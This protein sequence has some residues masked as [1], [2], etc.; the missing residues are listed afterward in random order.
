VISPALF[1]EVATERR[2]FRGG[3]KLDMQPGYQLAGV[4]R[5]FEGEVRIFAN[6]QV[7]RVFLG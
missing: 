1:P 3:E 2:N 5:T 7:N 4:G 6:Y